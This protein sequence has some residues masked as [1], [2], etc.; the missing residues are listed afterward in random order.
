MRAMF[1]LL[2]F[3]IIA[4]PKPIR[5]QNPVAW[6]SHVLQ[7]MLILLSY[8]F[9]FWGLSK[10]KLTIGLLINASSSVFLLLL[11]PLILKEHPTKLETSIVGI[12]SIG[13]M[14]AITQTGSTSG[15]I[16]III[17]AAFEA[18]AH[19]FSRKIL[20]SQYPRFTALATYILV[21]LTMLATYP[22]WIIP[23][24]ID[25][26]Y[27][28]VMG[29]MNG[30]GYLLIINAYKLASAVVVAPF[31]YMGLL[32]GVTIDMI[33]WHNYPDF[34]TITSICTVVC[35]LSFF[36]IVELHKKTKAR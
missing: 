5:I 32:W 27:F 21:S 4:I 26:L 31:L 6:R 11:S 24:S 16:L 15:V 29:I 19:L 1:T 35:A 9:W 23:S 2:T 33:F 7:A 30:I 14:M 22:L 20:R 8:I 10:V 17:G 34:I 28:F 18:S 36:A 25:M 3:T 13:I 12:G